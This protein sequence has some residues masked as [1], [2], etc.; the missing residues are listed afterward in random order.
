MSREIRKS[1]IIEPSGLCSSSRQTATQAEENESMCVEGTASDD[2]RIRFV[3]VEVHESCVSWVW[4]VLHHL[5]LRDHRRVV[6][7]CS[8]GRV[9]CGALLH[10]W[11]VTWFGQK[12]TTS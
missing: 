10:H 7:G 4:C 11:T 9:H 6:Y 2:C 12:S 5:G 3:E 8:A 1:W